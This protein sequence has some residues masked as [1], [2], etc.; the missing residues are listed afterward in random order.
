MRMNGKR[1]RVVMAVLALAA[2][3]GCSRQAPTADRC[4]GD[5]KNGVGTM[6]NPNGSKYSGHWKDG[7]AD[8]EGTAY[9]PDGSKAYEGHWKANNYDGLGTA[10]LSDGIKYVGEFKHDKM[11]GQGTM[12]RKDGSK[13]Y[14]GMFKDGKPAGPAA[15]DANPDMTPA[16]KTVTG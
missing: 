11:E 2:F 7:K 6:Y 10:Y 12:F 15:P 3:V 13:A 16:P 8:G 5:C 1:P 4:E 9:F 14:E